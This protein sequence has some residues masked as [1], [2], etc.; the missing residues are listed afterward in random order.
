MELKLY[1]NF[2]KRRNSTKQPTGTPI[3]KNVKLKAPTNMDKPTFILDGTIDT[4]VSYA[5]FNGSFF[6]I[7][8]ISS[9]G[10]NLWE[11]VCSMDE[12]ATYKTEIGST[13]AHIAYSSTGY[14]IN[15]ID[16][17]AIV[18][19]RKT[20][21]DRNTASGLSSDGCYILSV[22]NNNNNPSNGMAAVYCLNYENMSKI[23]HDLG[24]G[25]VLTDIA[26]YFGGKAM[27]AIFSC[28]WVPFPYLANPG[29]AVTG[30]TIANTPFQ[31]VIAYSIPQTGILSLTEVVME[32][33]YKY[34]DFRDAPPYSTMQLYLPGV[35]N[36]DI[37]LSDFIDSVHIKIAPILEYATGDVCYYIR[38]DDDNLIQTVSFNAA[39][40][41]PLAATITNAGGAITGISGTVA[42]AASFTVGALTG[43]VAM[44][45][46]GAMGMLTGAT[47]TALSANKR[48]MSLK[49]QGG[50][51]S[52]A[53]ITDFILTGYYM[54]TEDVTNANYVARQ[55]RPVAQTHTISNHSG[56]V[57]C[58][59]ASV[60]IAGLRSEAET[61]N[62]Y[63]NSGFYY[64]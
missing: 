64:E 51:R 47:S 41:T 18:S 40:V 35:G 5:E 10:N 42:G 4:S 34:N 14:D 21:Y 52:S 24:Q 19:T 50:S 43:N 27:D 36:I 57:Q 54:D 44:A 9:I 45:G 12:M 61:I 3:V 32:I 11:L 33:P 25:S 55:G 46:A 48:A 60:S 15:L 37:N 62:S 23:H 29:S 8:S 28:I 31:N 13:V 22:F 1:Q 2:A 7:E 49:G 59:N 39:S 38:D 63:L 56:F 16:P 58:I 20:K 53:Y 6:Y 17:R 26:E 30:I